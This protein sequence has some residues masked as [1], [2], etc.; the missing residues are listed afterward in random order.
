MRHLLAI[1]LLA[2]GLAACGDDTITAEVTT[3]TQATTTTE[4]TTTTTAPTTTTTTTL[5]PT[6]TTTT[7]TT[8]PTTT[9]TVDLYR[10]AYDRIYRGPVATWDLRDIETLTLIDREDLYIAWAR[11]LGEPWNEYFDSATPSMILEMG[12]A[13][14]SDLDDRRGDVLGLIGYWT[15]ESG[16]DETIMDSLISMLVPVALICPE[17]YRD[18]MEVSG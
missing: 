12:D 11:N 16:G 18:L 7:T 2:I 13:I 3:T 1:C 10:E 14:C 6:T 17:F 4:A 5:P 9:T 15:Q 8:V